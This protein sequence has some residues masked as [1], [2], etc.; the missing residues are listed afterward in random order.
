MKRLFTKVVFALLML[1]LNN[2]MHAQNINFSGNISTNTIWSST[3][4]DTV[5]I[6]GNVTIDSLVTLTIEPGI[7]V[8]FT[9]Y[10]YL[11]VKGTLRAVGTVTDSIRFTTRDT[12]GFSQNNHTGWAGIRIH[13]RNNTNDTSRF[14]YCV[15]EFGKANGTSG[16]PNAS[17]GGGLYFY[18]SWKIILN[19]SSIRNNYAQTAGG[20][21]YEYYS[22][23]NASS[24]QTIRNC[25]FKNNKSAT[26]GGAIYTQRGLEL[27]IENCTFIRNT[28]AS[29]GGAIFV[30]NTANS[31]AKIGNCRFSY[32]NA[33]GGGAVSVYGTLPGGYI[34][35]CT[36]NNNTAQNGG[37]I[38]V[39]QALC[40]IKNCVIVNNTATSN[41][42]GIYFNNVFSNFS[43]TNAIFNNTIAHNTANLGGGAYIFDNSSGA[44][45]YINKTIFYNN[46]S[47]NVGAFN[48]D[49][50][51]EQFSGSNQT[52]FYG[53]SFTATLAN[54][55]GNPNNIG[56]LLNTNPQFVNPSAGIGA[57]FEGFTGKNWSLNFCT[58]PCIDGTNDNVACTCFPATDRNGNPR[59]TN[60][61][62]DIG[63]YESDGFITQ[64]L[65]V[66][67]C[68]G[69]AI[70]FSY[71]Y[72]FNAGSTPTSFWEYSTN[73]GV[74]YTSVTSASNTYAYTTAALLSDHNVLV[75]V[76]HDYGC[77]EVYST[78]A[79]I[80]I[81]TPLNITANTTASSVCQGTSVTLSGSGAVSYSWNNGVTNGIAFTPASTN[82]YTVIGT[83][84]NGC[85]TNPATV[86]VT[87][88]NN[89]TVSITA[90]ETSIC[91]GDDVTLSGNGALSYLWNNGVV[92]G[93][94]FIPSSTVTY[95]VSGT[96][97]NSC[98]GT[99]TVTVTVNQP[100]VSPIASSTGVCEGNAVTLTGGG[101]VS[102]TWSHGVL[103][104][105]SFVPA[106]TA[107]YT[108]TG[109][110]SDGCTNTA[111]ITVTVHSLPVISINA[112]PATVCAGST[113]TL[114][115]SGGISYQWMPGN[116]SGTSVSVSPM[117]QT[118]YT[119]TGTDANNCSSDE[120]I[121]IFVL[122]LPN[123]DIGPAS[124]TVCD[125]DLLN[126]SLSTT[127][128]VSTYS[129]VTAFHNSVDAPLSF[130]YDGNNPPSLVQCTST[131]TNGCTASQVV[132]LINNS[133]LNLSQNVPTGTDPTYTFHALF[134]P[135]NVD[136]WMWDFGDGTTL[137][138][139]TDPV[140]TFTANGNYDVCLIATNSCDSVAACFNITINSVGI[141]ELSRTTK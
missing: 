105:V 86:T 128:G 90:S 99:A 38:Q 42:G 46:V 13:T 137:S 23:V 68:V 58:S 63:A 121:E 85:A 111:T 30:E 10:Y 15:V 108:V 78:V 71:D 131:G 118:I 112:N 76:R 120:T 123:A 28:A 100:T 87:V 140:H 32:N 14:S 81:F 77:R 51:L 94:S 53:C 59:K 107:T 3:A 57:A 45:L 74:N 18:Q 80:S 114:T 117:A 55:T 133:I 8:D 40:D 19:N 97:A 102:Y 31:R 41:G 11:N 56:S 44:D 35:D 125:G 2:S 7:V 67:A 116:L 130:L 62:V 91:N 104:G 47:S 136:N 127:V 134:I 82:T 92:N 33:I 48:N 39:S 88:N 115:A 84:G 124:L 89:P 17:H 95:T 138:G 22:F 26:T 75:R 126:F 129:I 5:K 27:A 103:D 12:L 6:T 16:L 83:D 132:Q 36:L 9:G 65:S 50:Y 119:V 29:S 20:G 101:A 109:E 24:A 113:T 49:V 72:F 106:A 70:N 61:F 110:D 93:V 66:S 34:N 79:T 135:A 69:D 98:V 4:I 1:L 60:N 122:D 37:A 21:L 73:G 64:P 25:V 54:T 52:R 43:G 139:N 141:E 96:D